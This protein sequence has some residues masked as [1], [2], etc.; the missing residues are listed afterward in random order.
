[1]PSY[2]HEALEPEIVGGSK[3]GPIVALTL[4]QSLLAVQLNSSG[5]FQKLTE[6][7]SQAEFTGGVNDYIKKWEDE[8]GGPKHEGV[9]LKD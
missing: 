8:Q 9:V 7:I 5:L 1:V 4:A 6:G 2:T 3:R